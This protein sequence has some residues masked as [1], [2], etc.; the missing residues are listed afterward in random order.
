MDYETNPG[1]FVLPF[2]LNQYGVFQYLN[3][4]GWPLL[5]PGGRPLDDYILAHDPALADQLRLN[6][7]E[8]PYGGCDENGCSVWDTVPAW[9]SVN[10][11][12]AQSEG[13]NPRILLTA[14]EYAL[15][16]SIGQQAPPTEYEYGAPL[17]PF[18]PVYPGPILTT[19]NYTPPDP[20]RY[21]PIV[22]PEETPLFPSQTV[23]PGPGNVTPPV[24]PTTPAPVTLGPGDAPN[25]GPAPAAGGMLALRLGLLA[26]VLLR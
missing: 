6:Y 8:A 21:P 2:G 23:T 13:V 7:Y 14:E 20:I 15:L 22:E 3:S 4:R 10:F 17:A 11:Q 5:E 9:R 25:L 26:L 19:P 12:R 24:S 1:Q 16:T 18:A